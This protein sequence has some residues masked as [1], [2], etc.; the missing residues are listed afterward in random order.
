MSLIAFLSSAAFYFH[1][2]LFLSLLFS[3]LL[4][5]IFASLE[6]YAAEIAGSSFLGE[7]VSESVHIYAHHMSTPHLSLPSFT[8]HFWL[9]WESQQQL[10]LTS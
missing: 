10:S 2:F 7:S 6:N 3:F 9:F 8:L 1:F 4:M 5:L